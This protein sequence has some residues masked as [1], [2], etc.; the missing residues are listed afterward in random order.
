M[1]FL[2]NWRFQFAKEELEENYRHLAREH[3]ELQR[4][5]AAI[6]EQKVTKPEQSLI[7][8]TNFVLS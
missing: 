1:K 3:T 5:Y 8:I 6:L 4:A 7:E 2:S